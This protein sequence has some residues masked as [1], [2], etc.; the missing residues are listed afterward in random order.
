MVAVH[1]AMFVW[2]PVF[3]AI[4]SALSAPIGA[5]VVLA[6]GAGVIVSLSLLRL[7]KSP[8]LCGHT[9]S[10]IAWWTYTALT[11]ITG[12]PTAPVVVWYASIPI[13]SLL[14]SGA[15]A[16][17]VWT[18]A[19][20]LAIAGIAL[21]PKFGFHYWNELTPEAEEILRFTG[22]LGILTCVYVLV[23][24]LKNVEN[25]GRLAL[26]QINRHLELQAS[27]DSLTGIA[28]RRLFDQTFEQEWKRH[29]RTVLPLSVAM[30]DIDS[31]KQFNDMSGHLA[32]DI[33][34][35]SVAQ[36]IQACLHRPGDFVAR[37]GGE[38]FA[39]I[40]PDTN[41]EEAARLFD[42]IRCQVKS[43]KIPHPSSSISPC[44]T[45]SVGCATTIPMRDESHLDFL[46]EAD[47]ALYRAKANGRDQVVH[48]AVIPLGIA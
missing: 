44:V 35:R 9:L 16:G 32:G 20:A 45:I 11:L 8:A 24:V 48:V 1:L 12:G 7:V 25:R 34:L 30:M 38:E 46:R 21:A 3:V 23:L 13:M 29:E 27:M 19:S 31:F 14:L 4:Y 47:M 41:E 6:A 2:V 15:T 42:E 28:N 5:M 33:C 43:M 40:L 39:V 37:F 10:F 18:T 17:H 36:V 22:L 26:Q